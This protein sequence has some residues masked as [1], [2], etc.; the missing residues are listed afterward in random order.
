MT[1]Q[2]NSI[3]RKLNINTVS[4]NKREEVKN[5]LAFK[6]LHPKSKFTYTQVITSENFMKTKAKVF[7]QPTRKPLTIPSRKVMRFYNEIRP[8]RI[9]TEWMDVLKSG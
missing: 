1:G 8:T 5:E 7:N 2:F 6:K 9:R 3:V 4:D